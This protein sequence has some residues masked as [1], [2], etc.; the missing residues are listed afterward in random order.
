M[1]VLYGFSLCVYHMNWARIEDTDTN[2][3]THTHTYKCQCFERAVQ[4]IWE[5]CC[6]YCCYIPRNIYKQS[7]STSMSGLT[8]HIVL[9]SIVCLKYKYIN[10]EKQQKKKKKKEDE[11]CGAMT[12]DI[13][14]FWY[15]FFFSLSPPLLLLLRSML[16]VIVAEQKVD[17]CRCRYRYRTAVV[18]LNAHIA[19]V[20]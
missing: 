13:F 8:I 7:S 1:Y 12:N 14:L 5:M 15:G 19:H 11:R 16:F 9:G 6:C 3:H 18:A 17:G 20:A 10:I 4:S 2:I